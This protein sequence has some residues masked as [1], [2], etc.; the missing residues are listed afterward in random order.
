MLRNI[1]IAEGHE[2][3]GEAENGQIGLEKF[4]TLQ[5]QIVTLDITMPV[6]DGL[7]A[8]KKIMQTDGNANVVMVSAAGQ[9]NKMVAAI[10]NGAI[11]FI[12]KPYQ[13]EQIINVINNLS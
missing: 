3:V 10:K 4:I 13:P 1:L 2:I 5:P 12:Q 7:A 11:E 9:K 8:L 6:M